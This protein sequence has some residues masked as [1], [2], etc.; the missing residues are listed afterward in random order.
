MP[1]TSVDLRP[2]HSSIPLPLLH[3][4]E[5][6]TKLERRLRRVHR[7]LVSA[8]TEILAIR[9]AEKTA[10][11][12]AMHDGLTSLP[13]RAYFQQ[14]LEQALL[15]ARARRE[16]QALMYLDLD[17]FEQCNSRF[18][19]SVGDALLRVLASRLLY[20]LRAE[21]LVGRIGGD[22]FA[23]LVA[24]SPSWRQLDTLAG[25]LRSAVS[26]PAHVAGEIWPIRIHIGIAVAGAEELGAEE[27]L[28]RADAAM[29]VAQSHQTGHAFYIASS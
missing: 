22:E 25:N 18:G 16:V 14:S 29:T 12:L 17:D 19:Q 10:R 5:K 26:A 28:R 6:L 3:D 23:C 21:D 1:Q 7:A 24:G 8:R 4:D 11:H 20:A 9:S 27:L 15:R 2:A 13:N